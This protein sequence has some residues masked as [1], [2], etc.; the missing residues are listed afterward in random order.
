MI[1]TLQLLFNGAVTAGYLGN[2]LDIAPNFSGTIFGLANTLSSMSGYISSLM[3]GELTAE[4]VNEKRIRMVHSCNALKNLTESNEPEV[5]KITNLFS[6]NLLTINQPANLWAMANC[7]CNF[8]CNVHFRLVSILNNG[9]WRT[10]TV[11]QSS[12]TKP[13][14]TGPRRSTSAEKG[15]HHI[16][17]LNRT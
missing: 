8:G 13:I 17:Q 5:Q 10:A 7:V 9:K 12:R 2:G 3:I 6:F 11:E 1:F 15:K 14:P 16:C 4:K